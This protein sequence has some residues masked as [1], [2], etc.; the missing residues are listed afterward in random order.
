MNWR[1]S[2]SVRQEALNPGTVLTVFSRVWRANRTRISSVVEKYG[3]RRLVR[4]VLRT[5]T[6][7]L[8]IE[9]IMR[10][11]MVVMSSGSRIVIW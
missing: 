6:A 10:C 1:R 2:L 4:V 9:E 11:C 3:F 8:L 5:I 7:D